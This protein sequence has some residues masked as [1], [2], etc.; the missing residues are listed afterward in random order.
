MRG[1]FLS[2]YDLA[3]AVYIFTSGAI[4]LVIDSGRI[5]T[6]WSQGAPF[7]KRLWWGLLLFVPVSFVGAKTAEQIVDSIPQERFRLV[8]AAFLGLIALQLLLFPSAW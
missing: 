8:I 7:D 5:A 3:K 4:G 2:A 6:Y 1:A